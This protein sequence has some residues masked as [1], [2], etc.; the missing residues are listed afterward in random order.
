MEVPHGL[1][2]T[3]ANNGLDTRTRLVAGKGEGAT[4]VVTPTLKLYQLCTK[5]AL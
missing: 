1:A 3:S 5:N 4:G 2:D